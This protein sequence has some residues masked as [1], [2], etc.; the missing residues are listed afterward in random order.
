MAPYTGAWKARA[1]SQYYDPM[2]PRT[3][4]ASDTHR[5]TDTPNPAARVEF[6]APPMQ[7]PGFVPGGQYPGMEWVINTGGGVIDQTPAGHVPPQHGEGAHG[8]DYGGTAVTVKGDPVMRYPGEVDEAIRMESLG[9]IA[10]NPVAVQRGLNSYDQNN[11]Q[12]FRRGI[13]EWWRNNRPSRMITRSAVSRPVWPN[14]ADV[15]TNVPPPARW[16]NTTSPF[17]SLERAYHNVWQRPMQRRDPGGISDGVTGDG[18]A[19][20]FT[21]TP[22]SNWVVG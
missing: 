12:G 13:V 9:P 4:T 17:N 5:V 7:D 20:A 6:T 3:E 21:Q 16:S 11:P 1:Q 14:T 8:I 22:V 10:T 2:S 15:I 18:A 19:A